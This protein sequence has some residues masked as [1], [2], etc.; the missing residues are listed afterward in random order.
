MNT[1]R[2][3]G[4]RSQSVAFCSAECA[5]AANE[6]PELI[7]RSSDPLPVPTHQIAAPKRSWFLGVLSGGLIGLGLAMAL[8]PQTPTP[9]TACGPR[10]EM[11]RAKIEVRTATLDFVKNGLAG[12]WDGRVDEPNDLSHW[13]IPGDATAAPMARIFQDQ[14]KRAGTH[15]TDA[16]VVDVRVSPTLDHA[17]TDFFIQTDEVRRGHRCYTGT[18]QWIHQQD[19]AWLRS[20]VSVLKETACR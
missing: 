3:C 9:R 18:F 4:G 10:N 5:S 20:K 16:E 14:I 15:L 13:F 1:C 12:V 7:H 2:W 17:D 11:G 8:S 6:M 19:G